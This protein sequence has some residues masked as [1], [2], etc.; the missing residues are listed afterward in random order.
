MLEINVDSIERIRR[1]SA[2]YKSF[3][4]SP[5]VEELLVKVG[6]KLVPYLDSSTGEKFK[7]KVSPSTEPRAGVNVYARNVNRDIFENGTP[8]EGV[9]RFMNANGGG[10]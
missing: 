10:E 6:K 3:L 5:G 1:N 7:V 9:I 4:N 2:Q 8:A